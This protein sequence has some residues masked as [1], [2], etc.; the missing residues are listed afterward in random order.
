MN[1][2][3]LENNG[4]SKLNTIEELIQKEIY[5]YVLTK[6]ENIVELSGVK[7]YI[8]TDFDDI[9]R[10]LLDIN[11]Y[12][13]KH[14][15]VFDLVVT[16]T[17]FLVETVG[18][19]DLYFHNNTDKYLAAKI[20]RNKYLTKYELSKNDNCKHMI[21]YY[22]LITDKS[23]ID[24][25]DFSHDREY[26]LKPVNCTASYGIYKISNKREAFEKYDDYRKSNDEELSIRLGK[27]AN[28]SYMIAEEYIGGYEI[29]VES[30]TANGVTDSLVIHDKISAVEPPLFLEQCCSSYSE[31]IDETLKKHIIRATAEIIKA[32]GLKNGITHIEYRIIN[33][34]ICLIEIN[35][36]PGGGLIVE[37]VFFSTGI[38][39]IS[40]YILR[41]LNSNEESKVIQQIS[42]NKSI[43]PSKGV[44]TKICGLEEIGLNIDSIKILKSTC[45]VGER[46]VTPEAAGNIEILLCGNNYEKL[47]QDIELIDST[48]EIE[49]NA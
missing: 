16:F 46:V 45:S 43:Y 4:I 27:S 47:L 34:A 7:D 18:L 19:I 1:V 14:G 49:V 10:L 21:P 5:V 31:R 17:E 33:D 41:A 20:A 36:R 2:L 38:N 29:S 26:I 44:V 30:I 25:L 37:S 35:L 6:N 13:L 28:D 42:I 3:C 12:C 11:C 32:I 24:C 48:I 9:D 39:M 23:D 15:I 8:V 22:K 40:E